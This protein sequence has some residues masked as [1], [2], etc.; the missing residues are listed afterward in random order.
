[1]KVTGPN[2]QFIILIYESINF[3]TTPSYLTEVDAKCVSKPF[4]TSYVAKRLEKF[5]IQFDKLQHFLIESQNL[6]ENNNI[7]KE[8]I[9]SLKDYV[10]SV[11]VTFPIFLRANSIPNIPET[12]TTFSDLP[13]LPIVKNYKQISNNGNSNIL[14]N[15][16][17]YQ[18]SSVTVKVTVREMFIYCPEKM[19]LLSIQLNRLRIAFDIDQQFDMDCHIYHLKRQEYFTK[20]NNMNSDNI[21]SQFCTSL[22]NNFNYNNFVHNTVNFKNDNNLNNNQIT[23]NNYNTN[24]NNNNN[25]YNNSNNNSNNNYNSNNNSNNNS[26]KNSDLDINHAKFYVDDQIFYPFSDASNGQLNTLI[27]SN[28][29]RM[30]FKELSIFSGTNGKPLCDMIIE[31]VIQKRGGI[32]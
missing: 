10:K 5:I 2:S 17:S 24:S 22:L 20:L 12:F 28:I 25:N 15:I 7:R 4:A 14:R 13:D 32:V 16:S 26:S 29:V 8:M 1:L 19:S 23:Y 9:N 3:P 18:E 30:N 21:Q 27:I 6:S 11:K 31:T